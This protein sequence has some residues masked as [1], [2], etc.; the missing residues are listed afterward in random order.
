MN[1]RNLLSLKINGIDCDGLN[2]EDKK[3]IEKIG[4]WRWLDEE[5]IKQLDRKK[6]KHELPI[7]TEKLA[8]EARKKKL[9][10]VDRGMKPENWRKNAIKRKVT[11]A[12][13]RAK[14]K[15][16]KAAEKLAKKAEKV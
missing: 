16:K 10:Y 13:V 11:I 12:A 15:A 7:I 4:Y 5:S 9:P 3:R 6:E 8:T 2:D 1:P 14:H